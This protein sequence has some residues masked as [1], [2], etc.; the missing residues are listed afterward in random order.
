M[1]SYK[2]CVGQLEATEL[3]FEQTVEEQGAEM[4]QII[5]AKHRRAER[6]LRVVKLRDANLAF[7]QMTRYLK[8]LRVKQEVLKQ[9]L[10]Y[11]RAKRATQKWFQRV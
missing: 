2:S 4:E 5:K 1:N 3:K 8:A 11:M 6:V 9:N 10:N 7:K